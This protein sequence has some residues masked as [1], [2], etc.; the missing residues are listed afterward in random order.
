MHTRH[1]FRNAFLLAILVVAA[2][3]ALLP[4]GRAAQ[5]ER[6]AAGQ[7]QA[8][9]ASAAPPPAPVVSGTYIGAGVL[10]T[11]LIAGLVAGN[12]LEYILGGSSGDF[13]TA[14]SDL[15]NISTQLSTLFSA[16]NTAAQITDCD[17]GTSTYILSLSGTNQDTINLINL[18]SADLARVANDRANGA[19]QTQI[20]TDVTTFNND[21]ASQPV[22]TL[23]TDLNTMAVGA[24]GGSGSAGGLVQALSNQITACHTYFSMSDS[25]LLQNQWGWFALLQANACAIDVNYQ[26][27]NG[28]DPTND[29]QDC[30]TYTSELVAAQYANT[31]TNPNMV[32]DVKTGIPWL[33]DTSGPSSGMYTNTSVTPCAN[34]NSW[35]FVSSGLN[36]SSPAVGDWMWY[37]AIDAQGQS[38]APWQTLPYRADV[39]TFL[40]DSNCPGVSGGSQSA[41]VTCLNGEG[42]SA[43]PNYRPFK[44]GQ[45][46]TPTSPGQHQRRVIAIAPA[47]E[48][49][50]TRAKAAASA[51]TTMATSLTIGT[52][53][54]RT[55]AVMP[56]VQQ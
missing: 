5:A 54:R 53:Q 36:S 56:S 41:V 31:I 46:A 50:R 40:N 25:G 11:K 16:V 55:Q 13:S 38:G 37:C 6:V 28:G 30:Q 4:R 20:T 52:L 23:A 32:I 14:Q 35:G 3:L 18:L 43:L 24:G 33:L 49:I 48:S 12:P 39:Q 7:P 45:T 26:V 42:F 8:L 44:S 1:S 47:V 27:S 2:A 34:N 10:L 51:F 21:A 29:A 17:I 19:S 15:N 22:S 9:V